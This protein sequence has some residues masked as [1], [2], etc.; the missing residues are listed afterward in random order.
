[1]GRKNKRGERGIFKHNDRDVKL[2]DFSY[3]NDDLADLIVRCWRNINNVGTDLT[4]GNQRKQT[5]IRE[6]G[7]SRPSPAQSDKPYGDYGR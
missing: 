5:A 1:M 2:A 4:T 6:L 7:D 3:Q